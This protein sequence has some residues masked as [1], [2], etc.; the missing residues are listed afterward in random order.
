M[1]TGQMVW[2]IWGHGDPLVLIHGDFGSWTHWIR[3]IGPL[4]ERFRV[5]APD[6]PGYGDSDLPPEPWSPDSLAALLAGGLTSLLSAGQT[7]HVA[8][9]SFGGIIAAHLAA[10]ERGRIPKL[11]LLGP[12][13]F[14]CPP[15]AL[16]DLRRPAKDM[17]PQELAE[18][19]RHNLA[20]LMIADPTKADDL[21][22][23]LQMSNA[24]K[25]R[26]RAGAIPSTDILV[27]ALP[28]VR[29]RLYGIWGGRDAMTGDV[30]ERE[31][32]LRQFQ[33]D[34][35]FRVIPDAGHWSPYEAADTVNAAL[36]EMLSQT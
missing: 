32:R 21:A 11:V 14:G 17:T 25:A 7:Y 18:V 33:Q 31:R 23:E 15:G 24:R 13:G 2:R 29:S 3:N 10:Q 8:G 12:G 16:P 36:V 1:P 30:R 20:A 26:I 35:D 22:V 9:F 5:F 6:M 34:I 19:H 27:R 28:R 4:S